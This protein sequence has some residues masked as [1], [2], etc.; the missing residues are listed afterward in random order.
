LVSYYGKDGKLV[1]SVFFRSPRD[2]FVALDGTVYVASAKYNSIYTISVDYIVTLFAGSSV[3]G[4][5]DGNR[6]A[7]T[8]NHP[9]GL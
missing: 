7:A 8:F 6:L 4:F 9:K 5:T 2:I 1:K 3:S